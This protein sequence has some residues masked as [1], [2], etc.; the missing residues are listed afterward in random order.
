MVCLPDSLVSRTLKD[1]SVHLSDV[2]TQAFAL[3]RQ[4]GPAAVDVDALL[5]K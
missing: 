4:P 3:S 2:S 1:V 5:G